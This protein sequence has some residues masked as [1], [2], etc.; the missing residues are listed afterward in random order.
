MFPK[1]QDEYIPE[2]KHTSPDEVETVVGPSVHVEG[3]FASEGNII[4]KGMVSGNVKTSKLLSVE[5]GAKIFANV[6]A[7]DAIVAGQIKGNIKVDNKLEL[8]ESDQELGDIWCKT[9]IV[10]PGALIMGRVSMDGLSIE[11]D[12]KAKKIPGLR[13][14]IKEF[15]EGESEEE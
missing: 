14:R 10:A 2:P 12:K 13:T 1:V 15:S 7:G 11:D 9:F 8:T 4:V 6:R 3:D 5:E